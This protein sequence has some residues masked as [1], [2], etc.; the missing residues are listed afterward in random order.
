M[1]PLA[2]G[3]TL[4]ECLIVVAIAGVLAGLALPSLRGHQLRAA[5]L[6]GVQA[7]T[8]VQMEQEKY[9]G[10]HGLYAG[11]LQ[12]L[13]GVMPLSP[14]GRYAVALETA[15]PDGYRAWATAIGMQSRDTECPALTLAVNQGFA[16]IGPSPACW[17]R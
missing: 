17:N 14:Q 7:L 11:E 8:R 12:A 16:Q 1:P 6:D 4:L 10:L 13:R 3:F 2:R 5:R 9:R 15:G